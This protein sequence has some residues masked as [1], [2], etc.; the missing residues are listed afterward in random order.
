MKDHQ[1]FM[2]KEAWL[3]AA[4][5]LGSCGLAQAATTDVANSPLFTAPAASVQ[6][7]VMFLL[8]DSG[9]M[10][11]DYLP[12]WVGGGT[13]SMCRQDGSG[14]SC[15]GG[16]N[17]TG[18]VRSGPAFFAQQFNNV[19]YDPTVTYNPPLDY[20]GTNTTFKS[21]NNTGSFL[22]SAVKV[23]PFPGGSTSTTNLLT[24]FPEQVF[25]D[26]SQSGPTD[27]VHCRRNLMTSPT[28]SLS[29]L[30]RSGS[31]VTATLPNHNCSVGDTVT[32][33]GTTGTPNYNNTYTV[34][35]VPTTSTFTF[36]I[37]GTPATP[38][39]GTPA[40][41]ACN[42]PIT[43]LSSLG[44]TA[45]AVFPTAHGCNVGDTIQINGASTLGY[46]SGGT[47]P[48]SFTVT[49]V[50]SANTLSYTTV[51]SNLVTV[52]NLAGGNTSGGFIARSSLC[53]GTPSNYSIST[54]VPPLMQGFPQGI[55][56]K[57]VTLNGAPHY[58]TISPSE[59]C[60]DE[61][62][63]NCQATVSE[64]NINGNFSFP[65]TVRYCVS[66]SAV[67][68]SPAGPLAAGNGSTTGCARVF[69]GSFTRA[70]Y[71]Y[72]TRV[73][74]VSSTTTY[75]KASTRTDCAG[76]TS[77][78][79]NEETTNFANWYAYYR[80]RIMMAKSAS[81][82]AFNRLNQSYRV[83]FNTMNLNNGSATSWLQMATFDNSVGGQKNKWYNDLY[84]VNVGNS[85][86]SR[87]AISRIGRYYAG[88]KGAAAGYISDDPIQY[89]CQQNLVF[90]ITDGFWNGTGGIKLDGSPM[91]DQDGVSGVARPFFDAF[92]A[93]GGDGGG[94]LADVAYYY[95]VTDLRTPSFNPIGA[96]G[97][98]V[99]QNNVPPTTKD[100]N[101]AQHMT[102]FT[103][104]LGLDTTLVWKPGYD[105]AGTSADYN[106]VVNGTMNWPVP[107][108]DTITAVD[109]LWHAAVNGRGTYFSAKSPSIVTSGL[110]QAFGSLSQR[111]SDES[112]AATSTPNI[113]P[114]DNF[115]FSSKYTTVDWFGE[116][117]Q[118]Q[119]DASTGAL[120]PTINWSAQTQLDAKVGASTDTTSP[121]APLHTIYTFNPGVGNQ[122]KPFL[123]ANLNLTEVAY[124]NG[125]S[126][127]RNQLAQWNF[128]TPTQQNQCDG[129]G[130]GGT[131]C[132]EKLVNY[133]RGQRGY[134][135]PVN[136]LI[137]PD[138]AITSLFRHRV[139]V[140]GDIVSAE[141]AY[142]RAPVF[143]YGDLGY[144]TFKS[145]N[146][147]RQAALYVG[148]N[149][150]MLH[151]LNGSTGDE[152]WAYIPSMVMPNMWK[153]ANFNYSTNHLFFVDGTPTTGDICISTPCVGTSDWRTILVGG[154]NAGGRGYYALDITD[155]VNPKALWELK[156][157][158]DCTVSPGV[159][160][161]MAGAVPQDPVSPSVFSDCDIGLSFGNPIITK[162]ADG[163]WV[164]LVTSGYNNIS[165][166]TGGGFL[167][168]I[169]AVTGAIL[170][171]IATLIPGSINAGNTTT[172]SGMA[173]INAFATNTDI[174]N[175]TLRLYG[176]DLN[177]NL[178]RFD[179]TNTLA[180]S[181]N[182]ATMLAILSP[183]NGTQGDGT[184]S[185]STKPE[186]GEIVVM[187]VG[188][189]EMVYVG[190]GRY[191]GVTDLG[192]T[193]LQSFYGIVDP[194]GAFAGYGVV[195]GN[196][197]FVQ[198]TL[199]EATNPVTLAIER[200][201]TSNAVD[202][203]SKHG[204]FI[205]FNPGNVSPGE[206]SN[207]DPALT[208]GI[209]SFV[210]NAPEAN[211][212]N[213]GGKSYRYFLN[214]TTGGPLSTS[215]G[216]VSGALIGFGL[217]TRP[218]VVEVNGKL[219]QIINSQGV[220]NIYLLPPVPSQGGGK[221][222]FWRELY[223]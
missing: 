94:T 122:L 168:V 111:T 148:A 30:T 137:T 33:V 71:G 170:N 167:Y 93:S 7:N 162:R 98:D 220:P 215:V 39:T 124:F 112:A 50:P 178:W 117:T 127:G 45:T 51:A 32:I 185:I 80:T 103:M 34:A 89:S 140:L 132:G 43:K 3:V 113:V 104:G 163:K 21:Y 18:T 150:G 1:L 205:D 84:A 95:Y 222:I 99:T 197:N 107:V 128:L 194:L 10:Q 79:Y 201:T 221:R 209:L 147:A 55:F 77:C 164:V 149:D 20:D 74:I 126:G 208:L 116:T 49:A 179:S 70:R 42:I 72:F 22:W 190:T 64:S 41:S 152:M 13:S 200:F 145:N 155:P 91:G 133:L 65:A 8:D 130:W 219:E 207:T 97:L 46:N 193:T 165:P 36:T 202:Y 203:T 82:I 119:L 110:L 58:Y 175:T 123:W 85:T 75:P 23:N 191:L 115:V 102:T 54:T 143:N 109:D 59:Y 177:G 210:T 159:N 183:L 68:A 187:G 166:G 129:G 14:S 9:S 120:I 67:N 169:D 101:T 158:A 78:T 188:T 184:H 211:S 26:G 204:W 48:A 157:P 6:P 38:A 212:C 114:G 213:T 198:Q 189:L 195:H 61:N 60:K 135:T 172:P 12:D 40:A 11:W 92:A 56:N 206:R 66:S 118:Q 29:S 15:N 151:A 173:R 16:G 52:E 216:G 186:L 73:N 63:T 69:A 76:A 25:C 181:G 223:F 47:N 105:T 144:S 35:S 83:G 62:L 171:K 176:G 53:P 160:V 138:P 136:S 214:Y 37:V 125:T 90:F 106:A 19:F 24:S 81:G 28:F 217:S 87:T 5:L 57:Q 134:E 154:L 156:S 44:T 88:M 153:L 180:T 96:L 199:T 17:L 161:P 139:H 174:D 196:T 27:A 131:T 108:A 218:V 141:A 2:R 100:P 146:A 182:T 192:T 4:M 142:V 121:G 31:T 86:P